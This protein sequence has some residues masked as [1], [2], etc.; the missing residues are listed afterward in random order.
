MS[1]KR[2][3]AIIELLSGSTIAQAAVKAGVSERQVYRWLETPAFV[4]ELHGQERLVLNACSWRLVSLTK[5]ALDALE[6]VLTRPAQPGA[7][8]KRLAS[9]ALLEM[10][11]RFMDVLTFEERL[12]RLE[13]QVLNEQ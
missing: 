7:A 12:E 6:D 3:L 13:R 9:V 4:Q 5:Q 11:L 1:G 10:S 8:N 2:N